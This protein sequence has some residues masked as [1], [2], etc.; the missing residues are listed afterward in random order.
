MGLRLDRVVFEAISGRRN[1][2]GNHWEGIEWG[3]EAEQRETAVIGVVI[4]GFFLLFGS[5]MKF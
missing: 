3:Q 1:T 5:Y 2:R 4:L